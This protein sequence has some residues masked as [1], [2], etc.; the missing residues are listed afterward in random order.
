M[1]ADMQQV[2]IFVYF[3]SIV[4]LLLI[5]VFIHL[6]H[7]ISFYSIQLLELQSNGFK[8]LAFIQ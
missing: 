3:N 6:I 8:N 5:F 2:S 7:S 1:A 4:F